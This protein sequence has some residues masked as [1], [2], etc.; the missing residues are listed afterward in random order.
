MKTN[1]YTVFWKLICA[2]RQMLQRQV[3]QYQYQCIADLSNCLKWWVIRFFWP[4]QIQL[5]PWC[6][7]WPTNLSHVACSYLGNIFIK[8]LKKLGW[9]PFESIWLFDVEYNTARRVL[10]L[11]HVHGV[12]VQW[13]LMSPGWPLNGIPTATWHGLMSISE[14]KMLQQNIPFILGLWVPS[15]SLAAFCAV[16]NH[17]HKCCNLMKQFWR[18][19]S[20]PQLIEGSH[21]LY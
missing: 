3:E 1:Q 15:M 7:A 20:F 14:E 5:S 6:L 18:Q 11:K 9:R 8:T 12:I 16:L 10:C 21:L 2:G 17:F 13:S 19:V 4:L